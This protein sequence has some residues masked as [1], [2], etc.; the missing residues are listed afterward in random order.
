MTTTPASRVIEALPTYNAMRQREL[1]HKNQR[2]VSPGSVK[3]G[4]VPHY[5]GINRSDIIE[6]DPAWNRILACCGKLS[7]FAGGNTPPQVSRALISTTRELLDNLDH[8]YAQYAAMKQK[9]IGIH[10][11]PHFKKGRGRKMSHLNR[12]CQHCNTN[13]TP[14]WRRG[15]AGPKTL[16]NA[17][18]LQYAKR[19]KQARLR[20]KGQ[21]ASLSLSLIHI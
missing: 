7:G 9:A 2:D 1:L 6:S 4:L 18:G 10:N 15:P 16:C 13:E 12:S 14:E 19:L 11:R 5:N 21:E 17:C 3:Q 8:L 20:G